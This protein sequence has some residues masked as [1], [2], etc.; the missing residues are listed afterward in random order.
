MAKSKRAR[1]HSPKYVEPTTKGRCPYCHK[2]VQS[3]EHHIHDK[4][5]GEK[6]LRG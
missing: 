4:H 5:I 3:I 6:I 2:P 1:R